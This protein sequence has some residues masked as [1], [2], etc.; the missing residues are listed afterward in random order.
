MAFPQ[1]TVTSKVAEGDQTTQLSVIRVINSL[2]TNLTQI[3]TTLLNKVQ[4]D[5]IILSNIKLNVGMTI[6]PHTLGRTLTGW[7]IIGQTA[8]TTK[9]ICDNQLS[10]PNPQ[11]NLILVADTAVTVNLL[12][13]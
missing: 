1:F 5:S 3:F 9:T 4:L 7:Q 12:V 10:N 13:F 2:I 8:P 11:T 6:I